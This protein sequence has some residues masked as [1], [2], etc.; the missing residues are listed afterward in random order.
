MKF[1]IRKLTPA[2]TEDYLHFFDSTPHDD[3]VDEHKCYCVCWCGDDCTGDYESRNLSSREKRRNYSIQCVEDGRI[4]GYLAYWGKEVVGWCNAN[5]KSDCLNCYGWKKHLGYAP[6]EEVGSG[7][8]VKSVFCFAVAPQW[9]RRGVAT[10]LLER[11]CADASA[12]GFHFVEAYPQREFS[13]RQN[14]GPFELYCKN[15][16]SLIIETEQGLVMRKQVN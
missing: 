7:L 11:V 1:G 16:F 2:L 13:D 15:G 14:G 4:Q 9:K 12:E 8:R 3:S 5:V 6:L 10:Q